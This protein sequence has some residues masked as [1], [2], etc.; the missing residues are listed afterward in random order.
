MSFAL[1]LDEAMT[2]PFGEKFGEQYGKGISFDSKTRQAVYLTAYFG[3]PN[4]QIKLQTA[5][6]AGVDAITITPTN[7]LAAWQPKT[8]Y[9]VGDAIE[10]P[11]ANGFFYVCVGEG[12]SAASA[13]Y[14][15]ATIGAVISDGS[16][17][18]RCIGHRYT[19]SH[20]KLA[21]SKAGLSSAI[22]GGAL[23]LPAEI[24]GG[25]AIAVHIQIES[26]VAEL[27]SFLQTWQLNLSLNDCEEVAI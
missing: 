24:A 20:V 1:Y 19:P 23:A 8:A 21:L 18:W 10:P 7:A 3:S 26:A 6:N 15:I 25:S 13:P 16:A 12:T 11:T 17:M 27:Y 2:V 14:F 5:Q 22:G 4:R 9:Q